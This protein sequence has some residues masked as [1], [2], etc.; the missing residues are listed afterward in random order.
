[1]SVKKS[2]D[3]YRKFR[4]SKDADVDKDIDSTGGKLDSVLINCEKL[5]CEGKKFRIYQEKDEKWDDKYKYEDREIITEKLPNG[6]KYGKI[7]LK[8]GDAQW[9]GGPLKEE[10]ARFLFPKSFGYS[11]DFV[12]DRDLNTHTQQIK[13]DLDKEFHLWHTQHQLKY[14]GLY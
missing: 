4:D 3:Y 2:G 6:K 8:K 11:T 14:G 12:N 10:I 7:P 5:T 13:L 9:M 1:K